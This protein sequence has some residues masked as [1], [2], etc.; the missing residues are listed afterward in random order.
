MD[1]CRR[2][3]ANTLTVPDKEYLTYSTLGKNEKWWKFKLVYAHEEARELVDRK[4]WEGDNLKK[5]QEQI[6]RQ[7]G[8]EMMGLSKSTKK[9]YKRYLKAK[10]AGKVE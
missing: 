2:L 10:R 3:N 5:Y 4:L 1:L 6:E 7:G 9:R 8:V